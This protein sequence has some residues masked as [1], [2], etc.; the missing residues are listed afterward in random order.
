MPSR[1]SRRLALWVP[2]AAHMAFIFYLSTQSD[3]MPAI[4]RVVWDKALHTSGYMCLG[5]LFA[6]GLS[7][8]GLRSWRLWI[9]ATA[10]GALYGASDEWHQSFVDGRDSDIHD[11]FADL[12]GSA[13]GSLVF[14]AI[15]R[16]WQR[17]TAHVR[18]WTVRVGDWLLG[19]LGR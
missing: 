14:I 9:I 18:T 6:R 10:V 7:G 3:P 12:I 8:E 17:A 5:L 1:T 4:T 2:A 15:L 16:L 13:A 11:W 19:E